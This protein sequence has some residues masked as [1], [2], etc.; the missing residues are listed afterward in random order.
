[1]P[2]LSIG[3]VAARV[4]RPVQ[5]DDLRAEGVGEME[6]SG[7]TADDGL[8]IPEDPRELAQVRRRSNACADRLG[9]L[10]LAWSPDGERLGA[11]S[12][13]KVSK[14]RPDLVGFAC[15]GEEDD[16]VVV[17]GNF[18]REELPVASCQLP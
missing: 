3:P 8:G 4:G 18:S 6:R 10:A 5:A 2:G 14:V 7:V 15:T 13:R 11:D 17:T 12:F 1:M 9:K 16:R